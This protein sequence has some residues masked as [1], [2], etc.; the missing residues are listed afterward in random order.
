MMNTEDDLSQ[1][2]AD[3]HSP[4]YVGMAP[5]T[6]SPPSV[7]TSPLA[8]TLPRSTIEREQS[9]DLSLPARTSPSHIR[10]TVSFEPA[11]T[12]ASRSQPQSVNAEAGPSQQRRTSLPQISS[13]SPASSHSS[14][15][16]PSG[17]SP[18][19]IPSSLRSYSGDSSPQRPTPYP[20]P[21]GGRIR[22]RR[23]GDSSTSEHEHRPPV[24]VRITLLL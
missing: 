10:P 18:R 19:K 1:S 9:V 14:L 22:R 2:P 23:S 7:S 11:A 24:L 4:R 8:F 13:D 5:P 21:G 6:F 12:S 15:S 16:V 3:F 20:L 17:S